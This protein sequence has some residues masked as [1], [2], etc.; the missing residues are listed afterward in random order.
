MEA[1]DMHLPDAAG[2]LQV[3]RVRRASPALLNALNG[4][5][6]QLS[7]TAAPLTMAALQRIAGAEGSALFVAHCDGEIAGTVCLALS[8]CPCGTRGFIEDLVVDQAQR[9]Q[10]TGEA[11][12]RAAIAQARQDGARSVDLT[13]RAER[14]A[15]NRLYRRLGFATR[16]TNFYRLEC[17]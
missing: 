4:L 13:C 9:G 3:R 7:A 14:L 10:G 11:L 2:R 8:H 5:L 15:A 1:H 17:R 6:R 12:V 16:A